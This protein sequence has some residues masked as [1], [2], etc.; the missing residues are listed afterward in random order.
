MGTENKLGTLAPGML[1]DLIVIN[2]N[3]FEVAATE[4]HRTEVMM[5]FIDGEKVYDRNK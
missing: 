2:Q 5:T 4:L 3:P 1:A